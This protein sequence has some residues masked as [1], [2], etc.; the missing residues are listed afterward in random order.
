MNKNHTTPATDFINVC[1]CN[2]KKLIGKQVR[3][4][5]TPDTETP[6]IKKL[7]GARIKI[8]NSCFFA[9][10]TTGKTIMLLFGAT[11]KTL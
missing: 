1:F 7:I 9:E 11:V 2:I 4:I 10:T 3:L 5:A 6:E 8:V